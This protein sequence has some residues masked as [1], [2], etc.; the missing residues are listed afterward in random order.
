MKD[1]FNG[2]EQREQR[3]VSVMFVTL[4]ITVVYFFLIN[5][6][7]VRLDK[8]EKGVA[9][10]QK[11]LSWVETNAATL[12][13][14]RG[15]AGVSS[16]ASGPLDQRINSSAR[17]HNL[18][19]NRLQPQNNKMQVMIDKAPFN[20]ILQ[21]VQ[22]LQLDYGLTVEIADFKQDSQQGFVKTRIVV[23]Q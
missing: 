18:T 19:I 22:T 10:E 3:L 4:F 5:P 7:Q 21:W 15:T 2:L 23:S 13:K 6:L 20:K 1:W 12:V 17:K 11:L 8:A 16:T 9:R 14:L